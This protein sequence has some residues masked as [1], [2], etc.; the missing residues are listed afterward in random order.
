MRVAIKSV[1]VDDSPRAKRCALSCARQ[2]LRLGDTH[3]DV[4]VV[5]A[6]KEEA[7]TESMV[8]WCHRL[9]IPYSVE[10]YRPSV[11]ALRSIAIRGFMSGPADGLV[12]LFQNC[13]LYP[14]AAAQLEAHLRQFPSTDL[15]VTRPK[16]VITG[17]NPDPKASNCYHMKN[18]RWT[19]IWTSHDFGAGYVCGPGA[20][21]SL[22]EPNHYFRSDGNHLFYSR[23]LFEIVG[24]DF[25]PFFGESQ[26]EMLALQRHQSGEL[27]SWYSFVTDFLIEDWTSPPLVPQIPEQIVESSRLEMCRIVGSMPANR[28]STEELPVNFPKIL[29]SPLEKIQYMDDKI[30]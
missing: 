8:A 14:V 25:L 30:V 4:E 2:P 21:P 11:A 15:L 28:S 29:M 23:R 10:E 24:S 5:V 22:A 13:F 17:F 20:H 18:G 3:F 27:V 12:V 19:Q 7:A 16:D 9:G 1:A 6:C 26:I